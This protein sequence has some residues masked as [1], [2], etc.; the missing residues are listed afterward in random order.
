MQT[1]FVLIVTILGGIAF[2][3]SSR[4]ADLHLAVLSDNEKLQ[5]VGDVLTA[6]LSHQTNIVMLERDQITKVR[7]ELALSATSGTDY[8][9]LGQLMGADGLLILA[10]DRQD[11]N[12]VLT[13]RLLAV[14]PGVVL[15]EHSYPWPLQD[16][17][18]WSRHTVEQFQPIF[19]KL[20]V[21][22]KNAVP[23]SV[24]SLRSALQSEESRETER[25]L[26]GLLIARL[27]K[28]PDIFVL[29]RQHLR[30]ASE[31]KQFA[32]I[33]EDSSFWAGRYLL[34]GTL[35]KEGFDPD[36][37]TVN[38]KLGPAKGREAVSMELSGP[39]KNLSET[40]ED[41]TQ[42]ILAG[43]HR[44]STIK[45]WSPKAE[46]ERYYE[47]SRWSLRWGLTHE[48]Q[49][50]AE[51]AWALGKQTR[52]CMELLMGA[53]LHDPS[54]DKS[55]VS[56]FIW[57]PYEKTDW[58]I[59]YDITTRQPDAGTPRVLE[60]T[61]EFYCHNTPVIAANSSK[62]DVKW[63]LL[64]LEQVVRASDMLQA[65]YHDAEARKG[66]EAELAQVR[67]LVRR[68]V[69]ILETNSPSSGNRAWD[70][71]S[72]KNKMSPA[73]LRYWREHLGQ[74]LW[75][76]HQILDRGW[77][78]EFLNELKWAM[79]GYWYDKPEQTL[80]MQR[81]MMDKGWFSQYPPRSVGWSWEDRKRVPALIKA[82]LADAAAS[83]NIEVRL[84][85]VCLSLSYAPLDETGDFQKLEQ[86]VYS[87]LWENRHDIFQI[88]NHK[89]LFNLPDEMRHNPQGISLF[90][91]VQSALRRKY[92]C[93]DVNK[94]LND[95][96]LT[97]FNA[98][99]RR[100][101]C[102]DPSAYPS[103]AFEDLFTPGLDMKSE[104][105]RKELV[106]QLV[107][108]LELPAFRNDHSSMYNELTSKIALVSNGSHDQI[109]AYAP[110]ATN[111]LTVA[112]HS[113]ATNS[114]NETVINF[115]P[116]RLDASPPDH[117]PVL[118]SGIYRHGRIWFQVWYLFNPYKAYVIDNK[119][120]TFV[121]ID[122]KNNDTVIIPVP[123]ELGFPDPQLHDE[124]VYRTC[125]DVTEDSLYVSHRDHL[126][127]YR[128]KEERW[129]TIQV[130]MEQGATIVG[131]GGLLYLN[132]RDSI[133]ELDP[134]SRRVN[135]LAS[136]RRRSANNPVDEL[137]PYIAIYPH[138]TDGITLVT[139]HLA[140]GYIPDTPTRHTTYGGMPTEVYLFTFAT[141]TWHKSSL[142]VVQADPYIYRYKGNA[143]SVTVWSH[144]RFEKDGQILANPISKRNPDEFVLMN[145]AFPSEIVFKCDAPYGKVEADPRCAGFWLIPDSVLQ[146]IPLSEKR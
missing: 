5:A 33:E 111:F 11:T 31:E 61:L 89:E 22:P 44:A 15:G 145:R 30:E 3:P 117:K 130:P 115:R 110:S 48:A 140:Q 64:G 86:A 54:L 101:F 39:R 20:A 84:K 129:E 4:G 66:K 23:I 8:V 102:Q 10:T 87:A 88:L 103:G 14:K 9:K 123:P 18:E 36:K 52:D 107:A 68:C 136:T 98:R 60:R 69:Q 142:P 104:S 62:P 45:D 135:V 75:L 74:S 73:D 96:A 133:L 77:Y 144:I 37:V 138:S 49:A 119:H 27:T 128:F 78:S 58:D 63:L 109:P 108:N 93:E 76:Q 41:L 132:T 106:P 134:N 40:V 38:A 112:L 26:T 72:L 59:E 120:V 55:P 32:S 124:P 57:S 51:S 1:S 65:Y 71:L 34:E 46:A 83:S 50:S 122:P 79:G 56:D 82:C 126:D 6:E 2:S 85:A 53:Y 16:M 42:K 21:L 131:S 90:R 29:E 105:D 116:L 127:R 67:S 139:G 141:A 92:G 113:I 97:D 81:E 25:E 94:P 35:D 91:A 7:S 95:A 146:A 121:G 80:R 28:E 12:E 70:D 17:M 47:E 125:F 13:A 118:Q 24:V 43:L 137:G 19:P 143:P 100:D 99:L 114:G